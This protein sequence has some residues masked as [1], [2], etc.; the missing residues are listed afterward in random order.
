[1]CRHRFGVLNDLHDEL[2]AE[3][4]NDIHIM[5]MNGFQYIDDSVGCMLCDDSCTSTTCDSGPRTLP[6][7]QDYD[8]GENCTGDNDG[9]CIADD[10][11]GD[12]W[13]MWDVILRDL[14]IL[15]RDGR[16]VT[17]INLTATNPDPSST[18]GQNYDTIKELLISIRNQ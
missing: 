6:W 3:G 10:T 17:R 4:I 15:D 18:C 5:G 7:T 1:M 8:D 13:D 14:V 2:A 11:L 9:L 12:V 16:Y